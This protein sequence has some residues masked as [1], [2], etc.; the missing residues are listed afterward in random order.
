MYLIVYTLY[1]SWLSLFGATFRAGLPGSCVLPRRPLPPSRVPC[2]HPVF[3]STPLPIDRACCTRRLSAGTCAV[4]L[5]ANPRCWARLRSRRVASGPH[6]T[7][8][9]TSSAT[10]PGRPG[11]CRCAQLIG[12]TAPRERRARGPLIGV[13]RA[14]LSH[15][16]K[17]AIREPS[18]CVDC[19]YWYPSTYL[20]F[21]ART[22]AYRH[23][24]SCLLGAKNDYYRIAKNGL[25]STLAQPTSRRQ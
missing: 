8:E 19:K 17:R 22:T 12:W 5:A 6:F 20:I 13:H 11:T 9:L 4:C 18:V 25:R 1:V 15:A 2:L 10:E 14:C 23:L 16:S 3:F 24:L 7:A 21:I